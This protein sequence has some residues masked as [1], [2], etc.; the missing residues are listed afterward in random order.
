MKIGIVSLYY[1]NK[2][3]GGLLKSYAMTELLRKLGH[4]AEQA[5]NIYHFIDT[6]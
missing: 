3:I 6:R 2:N 4:S 1:N 5:N